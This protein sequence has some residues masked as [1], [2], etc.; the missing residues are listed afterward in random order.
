M[1]LGDEKLM[2]RSAGMC[3]FAGILFLLF[4]SYLLGA[5][6]LIMSVLQ[7]MVLTISYRRGK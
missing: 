4:R 3:F 5:T 2:G 6:L 7:G 1:T